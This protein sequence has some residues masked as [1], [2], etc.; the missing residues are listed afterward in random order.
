VKAGYIEWDHR[1]YKYVTSE[2]GV[3]QG[4]IISPILSNLVLDELDKHVSEIMSKYENLRNGQKKSLMNPVYLKATRRVKSL[5]KQLTK[6][7]KDSV[8]YKIIKKEIR[9]AIV[10]QQRL[11]SSV[12]HPKLHPTIK[13]VRYADD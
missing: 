1:K 2:V 3:P 9:R 4:G 6:T 8:E 5:K 7:K 10:I 13:Y 12:P 11:N